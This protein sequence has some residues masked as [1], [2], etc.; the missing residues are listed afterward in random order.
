MARKFIDCRNFPSDTKCTV[1]I[2]ADS[3]DEVVNAAT[4]HAIQVHKHQDSAELRQQI[5]AS[6]REG[7]PAP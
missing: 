6:V 1:A 3:V 4:Q 7:N 5:R 2:S